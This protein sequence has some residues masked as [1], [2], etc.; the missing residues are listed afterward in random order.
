M[1]RSPPASDA[2]WE[3]LSGKFAV[4][5]GMLELL[6]TCTHDRIVIVSNYTQTLD[7]VSQVGVLFCLLVLLLLLSL[8]NVFACCAACSGPLAPHL[9]LLRTVCIGP[10]QPRGSKP[11]QVYPS[12]RPCCK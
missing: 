11:L 9:P 3:L 2:G 4:L 10:A 1:P 5:A 6:R 12:L 7:L 8:L